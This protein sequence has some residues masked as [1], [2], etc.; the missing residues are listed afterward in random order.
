M[1]SWRILRFDILL[2]YLQKLLIKLIIFSQP[3]FWG[4]KEGCSTLSLLE[5]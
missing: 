3:F 5:V 2:R 1:K 4:K